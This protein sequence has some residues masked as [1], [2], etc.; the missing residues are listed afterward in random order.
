MPPE[1]TDPPRFDHLMLQVLAEKQG[2]FLG[3][4][5]TDPAVMQSVTKL[6]PLL[7]ANGVGTISVELPPDIIEAA[8]RAKS[9]EE[10][11][12]QYQGFPSAR[13]RSD[14]DLV[15]AA[16]KLGI[17][18]IGHE[19][20]PSPE[21]QQVFHRYLQLKDDQAE[22]KD[23]LWAIIEPHYISD[24]AIIERD[25]YAADF[26]RRN[27][28]GKVVVIGGMGHSGNYKKGELKVGEYQVTT[29]NDYQ[30]LDVKLGYPSIDYRYAT[31]LDVVG[32]TQKSD[33]RLNDF[34]VFLP[35]DLSSLPI[36]SWP[37]P[38]TPGGVAARKPGLGR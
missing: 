1:H 34:T 35:K 24:K 25:N 9:W 20:P 18:C 17:K 23:R 19:K 4:W 10:L 2:V 36:T 7:K 31:S 33:G 11:S 8:W 37:P 5:H 22:E 28:E 30:G 16:K 27:R 6:M 14:Y 32:T 26:I 13:I 38:P 3:E 21:I 29:T 15:Q 12:A